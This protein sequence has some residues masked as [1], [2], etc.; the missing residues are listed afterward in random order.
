MPVL[1]AGAVC[2][3]ALAQEPPVTLRASMPENAGAGGVWQMTVTVEVG[4][5][6]DASGGGMPKPLIQL[7]PGKGATLEGKVLDDRAQA[8]N[9]YL[10]AP[11]ER[12]VNVGESEIPLWVVDPDAT[13]GVNLIA[14]VR[15]DGQEGAHFVRRR[16]DL[17]LSAGSVASSSTL[18]MHSN[19]GPPSYTTMNIGDR[20]ADFTLPHADGS[21]LT[22]SDEIGDQDIIL[23]TYRAFW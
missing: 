16:V 9:D 13:I 14:Y 8:R 12:L 23:T 20:A 15:K 11:Y 3:G 17:S 18:A 6:W 19:W 5:G 7:D 1:L 10:F 4:T 2:A 22:L 21:T